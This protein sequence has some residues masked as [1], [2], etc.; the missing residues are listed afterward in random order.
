MLAIGILEM[1]VLGCR[2]CFI[3]NQV[4]SQFKLTAFR[5]VTGWQLPK[6]LESKNSDSAQEPRSPKPE[7]PD[8]TCLPNP[9][10][11][12]Y[13]LC[14]V[15]RSDGPAGGIYRKYLGAD[16]NPWPPFGSAKDFVHAWWM[17]QLGL[18]KELI[19]EY[20]QDGLDGD[21]CTSFQTADEP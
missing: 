9:S 5:E 21:R 8:L 3:L 4:L 13:H 12:Q 2:V 10:K 15:G 14:K 18:T 11:T 20:L 7:D 19:D 16:W 17:L 6:I 1:T